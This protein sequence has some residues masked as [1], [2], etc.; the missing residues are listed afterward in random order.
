VAGCALDLVTALGQHAADR[1]AHG[2]VSQE[3]NA[4]VN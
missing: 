3:G 2:A 1:G 4:Y